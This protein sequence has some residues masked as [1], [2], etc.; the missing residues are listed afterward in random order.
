MGKALNSR[1]ESIERGVAVALL[2]F[3]NAVSCCSAFAAVETVCPGKGETVALVP[4][5]Q[6]KV[7]SLPTLAERLKA[8]KGDKTLRHDK[9]WRKSVPLVL[10]WK[11]TEGEGSPWKIE[12]GKS[13]DLSDARTWFVG[14]EDCNAKDGERCYAVPMANLEIA[15]EYHWRACI[16]KSEPIGTP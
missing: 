10:K 5:M 3:L 9:S 1:K 8:F 11:A 16:N 4:E 12:I 13:P 14:D 6:K 2:S 15:M 7:M